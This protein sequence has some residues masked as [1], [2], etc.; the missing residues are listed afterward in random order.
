[1]DA[2]IILLCGL[3]GAG[4]S[5]FAD[6]I[7]ELNSS[8]VANALGLGATPHLRCE[9]VRFDDL[10]TT[11]RKNSDTDAFDPLHW[12]TTQD[13]MLGHVKARL[14]RHREGDASNVVLV[15]LLDDTFHYRSM[16]KRFFHFAADGEHA[17]LAIETEVF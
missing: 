6:Q 9:C 14:L 17:L 11:A 5:T 4:K 13:E 2:T 1:M 7:I 12:K 16:R 3:P 15:L 8:T 10:Y